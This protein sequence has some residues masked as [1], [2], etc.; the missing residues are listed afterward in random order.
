MPSNPPFLIHSPPSALLVR[1]GQGLAQLQFDI[2]T[3]SCLD[4]IRASEMAR[5]VSA[6]HLVL[7]V[8]QEDVE[9]VLRLLALDN[10]VATRATEDGITALQ[11]RRARC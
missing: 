8:R 4:R 10:K 7:A 11:A 9:G 5:A 1:L 2:V 6:S 3:W